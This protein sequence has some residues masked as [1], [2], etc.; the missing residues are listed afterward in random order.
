MA[1]TPPS[2]ASERSA[3]R[4]AAQAPSEF[5]TS[6]APRRAR[7]PGERRQRSGRAEAARRPRPAGRP[8][9]TPAGPPRGPAARPGR[10]RPE[11]GATCPHCPPTRGAA[12]AAV[13]HPPARGRA[14]R[15]RPAR[16]GTPPAVPRPQPKSGCG[17][18]RP[19]GGQPW[20]LGEV[21]G[22]ARR[23]CSSEARSAA[24]MR[25]CSSVSRSRTVTVPS[26]IVWWSTVTPQGVPISSWRR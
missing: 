7:P 26:S 25:T 19:R 14:S 3:A 18:R 6:T 12:R 13:P 16:A 24:G 8:C 17:R 20:R 9:R 10:A 21:Q 22:A 5:P 23:P 4:S 15:T 2:S 1:T 11:A